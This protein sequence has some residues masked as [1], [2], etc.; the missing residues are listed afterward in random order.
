MSRKLAAVAAFFVIGAAVAGCGSSVSGNA[1]ATVAGNQI[2]VSAFKHWAY[3][4]AKEQSAQY[5]QQGVS[6]PPIISSDPTNFTSCEKAIRAG[7]PSLRNATPAALK[8]DCK[9]V[10]SSSETQVMNFLIQSYWLQ[11]AAKKAHIKTSG[12]DAKFEKVFDKQLTTAAKRK[13]YLASTLKSSGETLADIKFTYYVSQLYADLV[14]RNEPK[15]D[16]KAIAAYY[17]AHKSS[18]GT[19][20]T[21]NLHLVLTKS[22]SQAQAAYNAL[23]SGS[24]WDTVAKQYATQAAAKA[25]GGLLSN[26]TPGEEESAVSKAIFSAPVNQ[27]VGPVKGIFGYYVLQVIK[28]T[29]ATQESL[30]QATPAI[31]SQLTST[32]GQAAGT[33]VL[34]AAEKAFKGQTKCRAP[35]Y[36]S[37]YCSNYVAPKTTTTPTSS[38]SGSSTATGT[39]T[40]TTST[41]TA[42][43]S[44]TTTT[45]KK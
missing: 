45:K 17:Q 34:K 1:V 3:V 9:Q 2:S 40:A 13:A 37:T 21:R 26:I 14:K 16:A 7:I 42:S 10:Y 39:V 27:L 28:V 5:A 33:K 4:A 20:E 23:K 11:L 6:E 15:I 44:G 43:T 18:F 22:Q 30:A 36:E 8:S 12:I 31:K 35:N 19:A 24:S 32:E 41:G 25:D 38:G 29:P